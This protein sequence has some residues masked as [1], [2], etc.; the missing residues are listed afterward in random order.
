VSF[1]Q[2]V[3]AYRGA[4]ILNQPIQTQKGSSGLRAPVSG[5][6]HLVQSK[7]T[8]NITQEPVHSSSQKLWQIPVLSSLSP[9]AMKVTDKS[10][11]DRKYLTV[12]Y[13][14]CPTLTSQMSRRKPREWQPSS[15]SPDTTRGCQFRSLSA[16]LLTSL[17]EKYKYSPNYKVDMFKAWT[18]KKSPGNP[19]VVKF[20]SSGLALLYCCCCF[21]GFC[22]FVF[23]S[24]LVGSYFFFP[25]WLVGS[26]F[27]TRDWT[28]GSQGR[29]PTTEQ[30][31]NALLWYF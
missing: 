30:P 22:L 5:G 19:K 2:K 21:V 26:Y 1:L 10:R 7:P 29:V 27:L 3:K 9:D 23:A 31:G 15:R 20:P 14:P 6:A 8:L 12:I 11:R 18:L 25:S 28:Q 16:H 24:W 13:N 4:E 17:Y